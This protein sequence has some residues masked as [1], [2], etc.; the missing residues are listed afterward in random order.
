MDH[1]RYR[2]GHA[3]GYRETPACRRTL[4]HGLALRDGSEIHALGLKHALKFLKGQHK[5]HIGA[6][7]RPS[8]RMIFFIKKSHIIVTLCLGQNEAFIKLLYSFFRNIVSDYILCYIIIHI[9]NIWS[10]F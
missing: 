3:S 9:Y 6:D 10:D 2:P 1:V 8:K 5:V 7:I 4:P